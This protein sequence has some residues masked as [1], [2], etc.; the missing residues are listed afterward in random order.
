MTNWANFFPNRIEFI[1]PLEWVNDHIHNQEE[2]RKNILLTRIKHIN[3][4]RMNVQDTMLTFCIWLPLLDAAPSPTGLCKWVT[5]QFFPL[6]LPLP[7]LEGAETNVA[8]DTLT[9]SLSKPLKDSVVSSCQIKHKDMMSKYIH[10]PDIYI[11]GENTY[12][13]L[14]YNSRNKK[15]N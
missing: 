12:T 15:R 10:N 2:N 6:P 5:V 11:I 4:H 13:A 1:T 9:L 8:G 14:I 3:N 7:L